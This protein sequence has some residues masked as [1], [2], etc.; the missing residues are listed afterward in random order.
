MSTRK[1]QFSSQ[2]EPIVL[3]SANAGA[4]LEIE[5]PAGEHRYVL[6]TSNNQP[7]EYVFHLRYPHSQALIT[8][9]VTAKEENAPSLVTKVIHHSPETKA[10]TLI[11]TLAFDAAAPRYQGVI[12]MEKGAHNAESYLNHHSLLLGEKAKSWTLPSL[13]I[14]ADQVRCSHAATVKTI[15]NLDLFY[16]RSRGLNPEEGKKLLIEAFT[17][18]IEPA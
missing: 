2:P 1:L 15:T 8:G 7:Q 11:R 6:K 3:T 4:P 13:E 9:L 10:E 17:A 16:L 5:V 18:D 12:I 14:K